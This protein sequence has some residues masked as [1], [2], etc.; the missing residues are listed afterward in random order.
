MDCANP[1]AL[2]VRSLIVTWALPFGRVHSRTK[3][4]TVV[5]IEFPVCALMYLS[6]SPA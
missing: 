1:R 3:P 6:A 2:V 4:L 5:P